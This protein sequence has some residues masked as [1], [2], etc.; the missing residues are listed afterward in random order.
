MTPAEIADV[1]EISGQA[2]TSLL[3]SLPAQLASWQPAPTEWCVNEVVG[4]VIEAEKRG[5]A[6]RIRT[7]LRESEPK[8]QSWDQVG[9][10]RSRRDCERHADELLK[11]LES[12]RRES[13]ALIRA[14]KPEQLDRAGMHPKVARLTVNDLLHEWVHHDGNHLRQAYANVQV[15]VW[16]DMGNAQRFSSG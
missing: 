2:Y 15:Y 14:L 7:I 16:P 10:S 9:V 3:R 8:L 4:H 1:L 11:E 13:L 12:T 5:F 6:G